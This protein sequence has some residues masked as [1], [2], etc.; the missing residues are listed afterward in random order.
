MTQRENDASSWTLGL[1]TSL[2][3][4]AVSVTSAHHS[5]T[6]A[7]D[8]DRSID[9][10]GTVREFAWS[11][12]HCHVYIDVTDGR[13]KGQPYAVELGTPSVMLDAGWSKTVLR[14]GDAVVMNVHPSR[15]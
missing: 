2:I 14:R 4:A 1:M 12:P 9:I 6:A 10:K 3:V 5:A 13:V 8:A 15:V 7:Y 11:N